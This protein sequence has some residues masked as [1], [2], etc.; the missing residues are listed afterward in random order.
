VVVFFTQLAMATIVSRWRTLARYGENLGYDLRQL[1]ARI[2]S[3]ADIVSRFINVFVGIAV[4]L[5]L[6]NLRRCIDIAH[7][8]TPGKVHK[9]P[10]RIAYLAATLMALLSLIS[11]CMLL[12]LSTSGSLDLDGYN[13][14]GYPDMNL[15]I[16][17]TGTDLSAHSIQFIAALTLS[18]QSIIV[19]RRCRFAASLRKVCV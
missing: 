3:V 2:A 13:D 5:T 4:F 15:V 10:R 19:K 16:V 12:Y 8:G 1:V 9:W 18:I 7:L 17:P 11:L 14:Y 6:V